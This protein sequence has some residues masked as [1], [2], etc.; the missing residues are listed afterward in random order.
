METWATFSIVDHRRPIYRQALALFDRI[1]V[2]LPPA[3]IG[4]QTREELD[5]LE[6]ELDY[7][8]SKNAARVY[9]WRSAEFDQWRKPLLAESI[10]TG[11]NRD[12]LL[13]TRLM[14]VDEVE[15]ADVQALP[16]YGDVQQYADM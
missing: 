2:P 7:L 14:L 5:Q 16:V 15:A 13:D 10:A 12:P 8:T 9:D 6:A 11:L 1:V 4:D 3:P